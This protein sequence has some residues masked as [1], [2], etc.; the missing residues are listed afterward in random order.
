M[1]RAIDCGGLL[2]RPKAQVHSGEESEKKRTTAMVSMA[3]ASPATPASASAAV[4]AR[5]ARLD[6][7]SALAP[8]STYWPAPTR[9]GVLPGISFTLDAPCRAPRGRHSRWRQVYPNA[10][11]WC[12][13]AMPGV[14]VGIYAD[15]YMA[16]SRWVRRCRTL[17]GLKPD[18]RRTPIGLN[19]DPR[20]TAFRRGSRAVAPADAWRPRC[21]APRRTGPRMRCRSCGTCRRARGS[22][23]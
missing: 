7:D 10:R 18:P 5:A 3:R 2:L 12:A 21:P 4:A 16:D 13:P 17:F 15:G 19:P 22:T 1:S 20:L 11:R 9:M 6:G 23:R 14:W 8:R